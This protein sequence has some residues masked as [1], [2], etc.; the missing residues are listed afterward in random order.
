[1]YDNPKPG[2]RYENLKTKKQ[3]E[4]ITS[5]IHAVNGEELIILQSSPFE[6]WAMP[7]YFL[8]KRFRKL[9]GDETLDEQT[10]EHG[11]GSLVRAGNLE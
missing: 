7:K 8:L 6:I 9:K 1:M 4:V 11:L 3:Y 10:G 5:A 2:E